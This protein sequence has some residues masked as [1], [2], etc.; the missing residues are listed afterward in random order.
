M[1]QKRYARIDTE[2]G[3]VYGDDLFTEDEVSNIN[4]K[5]EAE[6]EPDRWVP[7]PEQDEAA[8]A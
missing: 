8:A 6:G 3:D 4:Q 7:W 5:L 1:D 2:N